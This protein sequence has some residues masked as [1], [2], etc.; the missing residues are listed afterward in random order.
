MKIAFIRR[1]FSPTIGGAEKYLYNLS[2]KLATLGEEIHIF[3][4]TFDK[5]LHST[6]SIHPVPI[7]SINSPLK[8]LSFA[9]NAQKELKKFSFDIICSLSRGYYHDVFRI[10]DGI[11]YYYLQQNYSK[12]M[13]H[14]VK[15]ISLRHRTILYLEKKSFD[16]PF[17]K[18]IIANSKLARDQVVNYYRIPKEMV[19]VIYN[20]I[21]PE[22]F[23]PRVK[24]K[25]QNLMRQRYGVP[26]HT[27]I[28]LFIGRDYK[29]KGLEPLLKALSFIKEKNFILII[30]GKSETGRYLSLSKKL[31]LMQNVRFIGYHS[32]PEE[33]YGMG[34][35][36][37]LPSLYDPFSNSCLEAL[38]CGL[39]VITTRQNGA[40][41]LI[42]NGKNGFIIENAF[43]THALVK[44]LNQIFSRECLSKMRIE[45]FNSV[46]GLT[47][48]N[49]ALEIQKLFH[50]I[51]IEKQ[52]GKSL[53]SN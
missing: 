18:R 27:F 19:K 23:N 6:I 14:L 30:A 39:P 22:I 47:I 40:S 38:A 15:Y 17:L 37:V 21:N 34:D 29:R 1:D 12:L 5:P 53:F 2:G 25:Y 50:E 10:S 13:F 44:Y 20:G 9:I 36:L 42:E 33:L 26:P 45:A 3:A 52:N 11:H 28:I 32:R 4:N 8:N 48:E 46:R 31:G 43:C 24:D 49:N 51:L 16:S 7:I 41:E 35:V